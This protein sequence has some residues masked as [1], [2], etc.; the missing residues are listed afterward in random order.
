MMHFMA[1]HSVSLLTLGVQWQSV[2]GNSSNQL[3]NAGTKC[4]Y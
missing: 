3:L 1:K 4:T 2:L